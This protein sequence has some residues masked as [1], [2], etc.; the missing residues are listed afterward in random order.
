MII[1]DLGKCILINN[2]FYYI[3][4]YVIESLHCRKLN[5]YKKHIGQVLFKDL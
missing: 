4:F 2:Y 1:L 5:N 3:W